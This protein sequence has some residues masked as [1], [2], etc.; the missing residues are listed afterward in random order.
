[1]EEENHLVSTAARLIIEATGGETDKDTAYEVAQE[2][3]V[4][5]T[6]QEIMCTTLLQLFI[7]SFASFARSLQPDQCGPDE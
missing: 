7:S 4:N 2:G 1:M 5:I 3:L 6:L